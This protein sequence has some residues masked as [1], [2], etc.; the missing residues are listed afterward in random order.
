M[1]WL[2]HR[3]PQNM[4]GNILYPLNDLKILHPDVYAEAVKKYDN[5]LHALKRRIPV[6]DCLWNDVIHMSSLDPHIIKAELEKN[7]REMKSKTFFKIDPHSLDIKNTLVFL[8][9][10]LER[11]QPIPNDYFVPFDPS[12][13][14]QYAIFPEDT[15]RYFA[16]TIS[17]G[18]N[19]LLWHLVPHILYKGH[20]DVSKFELLEL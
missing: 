4:Q 3:R 2:Y 6:L 18:G 7:G 5:R 15:K 11:G 12:N 17:H 8:Y 19:P 10:P 13:V 1:S 16:E 20:I 9:K 14:E